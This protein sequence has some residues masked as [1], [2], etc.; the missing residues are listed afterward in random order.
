M[1]RLGRAKGLGWVP[2]GVICAELGTAEIATAVRGARADCAGGDC[3]DKDG[4]SL[5]V[6]RNE[7]RYNDSGDPSEK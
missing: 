5:G 2:A 3:L 7:V 4:R 1:T 6:G